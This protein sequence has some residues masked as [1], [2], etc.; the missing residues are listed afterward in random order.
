MG[1]KKLKVKTP[2]VQWKDLTKIATFLLSMMVMDPQEKKPVKPLMIIF[3]LIQKKMLRKLRFSLMINKERFF[4]KAGF[5]SAESKLK[6]SGID[7][8]NSGTCAIA[9]Y[10]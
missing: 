1:L 4:L 6:S 9:V 2:I 5:K 10:I 8:S 3:K 7:Y